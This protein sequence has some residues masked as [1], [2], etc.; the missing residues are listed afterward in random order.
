MKKNHGYVLRADTKREFLKIAVL[1]FSFTMTSEAGK[2]SSDLAVDQLQNKSENNKNILEIPK[3]KHLVGNAFIR[4][5]G[6]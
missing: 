5:L 4:L 1:L 2:S 6:H 3:G